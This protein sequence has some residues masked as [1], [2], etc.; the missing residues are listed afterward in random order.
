MTPLGML[1]LGLSI[2]DAAAYRKCGLYE[3][4]WRFCCDFAM[5]GEGPRPYYPKANQSL[6]R[7]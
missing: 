3:S 5:S 7:F 4:V 2:Y 1:V 6:S